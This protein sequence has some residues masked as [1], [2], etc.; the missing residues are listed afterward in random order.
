[1]DV[2]Q[3]QIV[4]L[5]MSSITTH[6][7]FISVLRPHL[8]VERGQVGVH[9]RRVDGEAGALEP[10]P[11]AGDGLVAALLARGAHERH[12]HLHA[13]LDAAPHHGVVHLDAVAAAAQ[14]FKLLKRC[15]PPSYL[16]ASLGPT[17]SYWFQLW[18]TPVLRCTPT[19]PP[20]G[21]ANNRVMHLDDLAG[22]VHGCQI[23][24]KCP[25]MHAKWDQLTPISSSDGHCT[26]WPRGAFSASKGHFTHWEN[27]GVSFDRCSSQLHKTA[28]ATAPPNQAAYLSD[29][30]ECKASASERHHQGNY[31][32]TWR[33]QSVPPACPP[34]L[35][36]PPRPPGGWGVGGQGTASLPPY[37][38]DFFF[39]SLSLFL[40]T[41]CAAR[42]WWPLVHALMAILYDT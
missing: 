3:S 33:Q 20:G 41:C 32:L 13:R 15:A 25:T 4:L 2:K 5:L 18:L 1:M 10:L 24:T 8:L 14:A 7:L 22:P 39:F 36:E 26:S 16:I 23:G 40:F 35:G 19:A 11:D 17:V 30:Q 28:H 27:G 12:Q 38:P 21:G 29:G 31:A 37:I 6:T 42:N 34:S 9:E